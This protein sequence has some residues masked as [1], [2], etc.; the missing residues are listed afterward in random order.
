MGKILDEI[1]DKLND[2]RTR[3]DVISTLF[4][5][6]IG[7][8]VVFTINKPVGLFLMLGGAGISYKEVIEVVKYFLNLNKNSKEMVDSPGGNQVDMEVK[9]ESGEDSISSGRDTFVDKSK[10][11]YKKEGT[12]FHYNREKRN[13]LRQINDKIVDCMDT[14]NVQANGGIKNEEDYDKTTELIDDFKKMKMKFEIEFDDEFNNQLSKVLGSFRSVHNKLLEKKMEKAYNSGLGSGSTNFEFIKKCKDTQLMIKER[15]Y[16]IGGNQAKYIEESL[17]KRKIELSLEIKN[18]DLKVDSEKND[19]FYFTFGMLLR[20]IGDNKKGI[21]KVEIWYNTKKDADAKRSKFFPI[22]SDFYISGQEAV[23]L[24]RI[25]PIKFN[26]SPQEVLFEIV[27]VDYQDD[28]YS[29]LVKI[30]IRGISKNNYTCGFS[31]IRGLEPTK[32]EYKDTFGFD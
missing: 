6:I 22:K 23:S 31:V 5:L 3:I 13:I 29:S 18:I 32:F 20:N 19:T 7:I 26:D 30:N 25:C 17:K 10:H 16:S 8:L 11:Y 21:K 2:K 24:A 12:D 14:L 9:Q 27:V 15:L 4:F 1:R 28:A